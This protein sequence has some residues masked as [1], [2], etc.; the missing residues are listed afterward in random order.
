[1]D[2]KFTELHANNDFCFLFV[3]ILLVVF[4]NKYAFFSLE[5]DVLYLEYTIYLYKAVQLL[6]VC[7]TLCRNPDRS[8]STNFVLNICEY[9]L[10]PMY[11]LT[12]IVLYEDFENQINALR[13]RVMLNMWWPSNVNG[14]KLLFKAVR[15]LFWF[16]VIEIFLHYIYA[17]AILQS[18]FTLITGLNNY[19]VACISYMAGI[20]FYLKY[21]IIFGLPSLFALID[22]MAPPGPPVCISRISKYSQMWRYFDRGLYEF[23]KHQVYI[24]FMGDAKGINLTIR[25][26]I[27]MV[28]VFS[29]VIAWHGTKSNY[30]IWVTL[31][32]AEIIMERIGMYD[33]F[34]TTVVCFS[35]ISTTHDI[36]S[37]KLN[38]KINNKQTIFSAISLSC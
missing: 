1:M 12:L 18:A 27:A 17:N 37:Q 15:L 11:S 7:I 38:K 5:P 9:L 33:T 16:I 6:N 4:A 25:R 34:T 13:R 23:L 20:F 31:S 36:L 3:C 2:Y 35:N 19:E 21:V 14:Q 22:G 26:L 24:P 10:Y 29:F 32:A 8:L 30:L 28:G